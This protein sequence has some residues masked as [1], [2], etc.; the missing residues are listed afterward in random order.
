MIHKERCF[1][2][3]I[4]FPM[5][6]FPY[7]HLETSKGQTQLTNYNMTWTTLSY[8]HAPSKVVLHVYAVKHN[9][10]HFSLLE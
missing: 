7:V 4:E 1:V 5:Y 10:R 9:V 2:F 8:D 6:S 3:K